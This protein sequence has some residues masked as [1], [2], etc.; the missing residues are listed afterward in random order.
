MTPPPEAPAP[1]AQEQV[2][3]KV[4]T[5]N[6]GNQKATSGAL[7]EL[8][9]TF[10]NQPTVIALSTQEEFAV[11]DDRLHVKLLNKL[12]ENLKEGE[13]YKLVQERSHSTSA[14]MNNHKEKYFQKS[15]NRTSTAILVKEPYSMPDATSRVDFQP[16]KSSKK[17]KNKKHN[18]SLIVI[19]GTLK[20]NGKDILPIS[21]AGGHIDSKKESKRRRHATYFLRKEGLLTDGPSNKTY[22][23]IVQEASTV[24]I[25]CGD[26][27]ERDDYMADG[28][29]KPPKALQTDGFGYDAKEPEMNLVKDG[30]KEKLVG[31][32]GMVYQGGRQVTVGSGDL[33]DDQKSIDGMQDDWMRRGNATFGYLDQVK[34]RT[35]HDVETHQYGADIPEDS[36]IKGKKEC[37]HGSDHVYVTREMTV[38]LL[39]PRERVE[40]Y[41]K[42]RMPD[43]R[44]AFE[45]LG[46]LAV[47]GNMDEMREIAKGYLLHCDKKTVAPDTVIQRLLGD[48]STKGSY[49][50]RDIQQLQI[51]IRV[52][53]EKLQSVMQRS[54]D[55]SESLSDK[56]EKQLAAV[57]N[58]LTDLNAMKNVV[59]EFLCD[60]KLPLSE[61]EKQMFQLYA[62]NMLLDQ[63]SRF[64]YAAGPSPTQIELD[65]AEKICTSSMAELNAFMQEHPDACQIFNEQLRNSS[66]HSVQ[67]ITSLDTAN[68]AKSENTGPKTD[69]ALT[70]R[71]DTKKRV[72]RATQQV[73]NV[74][75]AAIKHAVPNKEG[76]FLTDEAKGTDKEPVTSRRSKPS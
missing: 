66:L 25:E 5:W 2:T 26:L 55:L 3:L 45:P 74:A 4:A 33:K 20:K 12:N 35:G 29:V 64:Y 24:G 56:S 10:S 27:N 57:F 62:D 37:L 53:T 21:I 13:R 59:F 14:G 11:G 34:V 18:K 52:Q 31:T 69:S 36:F 49:R 19:K 65:A 73:K 32:Y 76:K 54:I 15:N 22:A 39:D 61:T 6:M 1:Q 46:D 7:D 72:E 67:N 75:K 28:T 60:P 44:K 51:K 23:Q 17:N 38:N 43:F 40:N 70:F 63:Y 68:P 58:Q 30:K 47:A 41:I 42:N 16:S 48:G 8:A 71:F 9:K 50:D